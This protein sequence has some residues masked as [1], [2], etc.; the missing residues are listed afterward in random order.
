MSA[1]IL[2]N[3]GYFVASRGFE[4]QPVDRAFIVNGAP[5]PIR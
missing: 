2:H 3:K 1:G 5:S 4:R